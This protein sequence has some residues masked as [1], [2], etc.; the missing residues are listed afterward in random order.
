MALADRMRATAGALKALPEV[1]RRLHR[2]EALLAEVDQRTLVLGQ[3]V[4]QLH[5]VVETA[6]PQGTNEIL[7]GVRDAVSRLSIELTEQANHTS[8][9]LVQMS[10]TQELTETQRS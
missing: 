5:Q 1:N 10:A 4:E 9:L 6:D 3:Q 2:V 8:E 7:V